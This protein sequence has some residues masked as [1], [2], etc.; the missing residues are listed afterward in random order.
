[1]IN[2]ANPIETRY[3][4]ACADA[5]ERR[6]SNRFAHDDRMRADFAE[7]ESI[8]G[9]AD[10]IALDREL[11]TRAG[12]VEFA[13]R[14]WTHVPL[15][16]AIPYTHGRI[17]DEVA[18]HCEALFWG[19][20]LELLINQPPGTG[21]SIFFS[22]LFPAWIWTID[23]KFRLMCGSYSGGLAYDQAD[24]TYALVSSQWYRE[25]WGQ[26][27][28]ERVQKKSYYETIQGGFR[29]SDAIGGKFTGKHCHMRCFDDPIKPMSIETMHVEPA[30][31]AQAK[32]WWIGTMASRGI[33][34][35][36]FR[37]AGIMQRVH[38]DDL[39]EHCLEN[40]Y[41]NLRL[42]MRYEPEA[43]CE[44]PIG[45]DW[46]TVEGEVVM[47]ELITPELAMQKVV[48]M[49]GIDSLIDAAQNQQRPAPKGGALFKSD[50]FRTFT[51]EDM[52]FNST[53]AI[54]SVDCTFKDS[55]TSDYVAIEVWGVSDNRFYCYDS[56]ID[57]LDLEG[58][59]NAVLA[60]RLEWPASIVLVEEKAN[61]AEV[62]RALGARQINVVPFLPKASKEARAQLAATFYSNKLVYHLDAPWRARKEK[63]LVLFPNGRHDDDV[64]ATSQAVIFMSELG[65]A[66][67]AAAWGSP[68]LK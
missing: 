50:C 18:R 28:D 22:I 6:L 52:P 3:A 36:P 53:V 33:P 17:I 2:T 14:A 10:S 27:V 19:E 62:I 35:I 8:L 58:T 38:Q 39:S 49:G 7:C 21:K 4:R 54:I 44:T 5:W 63:N 60:T 25:R 31:L 9:D 42:P 57:R 51:L 11:I 56:R 1:M 68:A 24:K 37:S 47:P 29:L 26:L 23:P 20:F 61:G 13:R 55:P 59:I 45:G 67:F 12:F 34:G 32:A 30:A 40:G 46:R 66:S 41:V 43:R 64:D 16:G 48:G 65:L 15:Y